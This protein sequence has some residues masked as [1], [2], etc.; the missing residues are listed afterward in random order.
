MLKNLLLLSGFST[1]VVIVIVGFNIYHNYTLTS[2]PTST[3]K[4]VTSIPANFDKKTLNELKKR[5]PVIINLEEKSSVISED[6]KQTSLL[7]PTPSQTPSSSQSAE[8]II[9]IPTTPNQP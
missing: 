6:T 1:F 4:H 7:S 5:V 8:P 9:T 2:L 3:Q